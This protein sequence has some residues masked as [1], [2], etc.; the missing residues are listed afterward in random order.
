MARAN[1][2]KEIIVRWLAVGRRNGAATEAIAW[3]ARNSMLIATRRRASNAPRPAAATAMVVATTPTA[4]SVCG[5]E[6]SR[7]RVRLA[8]HGRRRMRV[9]DADRRRVVIARTVS[10]RP[11][12]GPRDGGPVGSGPIDVEPGLGRA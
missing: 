4:S 6:D 7:R 10:L 1:R 2:A 3:A 12:P 5:S 11:R 9:T 8:A